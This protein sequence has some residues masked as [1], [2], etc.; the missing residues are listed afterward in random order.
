[1]PARKP[2]PKAKPRARA[3]LETRAVKIP[4]TVRILPRSATD[5]DI[6][7]AVVDWSELLAESKYDAALAM[8]LHDPRGKT[9][10]KLEA[11]IVNYGSPEPI[12]GEP[13]HRLTSLRAHPDAAT[14]IGRRMQVDRENLYGR[15]PR[16][17]LGMV[18]YGYVPLDGHCSDLTARFRIRKIGDDRLTLEFV[19]IHVM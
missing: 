11:W 6:K 19:D 1:M 10:K 8:F 3:K 17:Y 7:S 15:D 13:Q 18:H 12:P 9:P 14:I 5:A 16:H 2:K 4:S